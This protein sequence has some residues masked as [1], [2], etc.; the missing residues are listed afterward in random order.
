[1]RHF[2]DYFTELGAQQQLTTPYSPPQNGIVEQCNQTVV[3]VARYMLKA[4]DLPGKFWREAVMTAI[5]VLN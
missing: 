2:N 4:R 1:V 5:Y 3:R